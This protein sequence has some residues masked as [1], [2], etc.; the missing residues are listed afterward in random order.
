M[1]MTTLTRKLCTATVGLMLLFAVGSSANAQS[2]GGRLS[3]GEKVGAIGGGAAAGAVIG[4]LLGGTKGAIIGGA[5]GAAGGT[6]Y[7]ATQGRDDDRYRR[8]SGDRYYY[9]RDR[10]YWN[11]RSW[12]ERRFENNRWDRDRDG[13]HDRDDRRFDSGRNRWGYD[14]YRR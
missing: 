2:F 8:Y 4:G 14:R 13:D 11:G 1:K 3:N 10:Y 9:D 7:V 5:L 12:E 6:A